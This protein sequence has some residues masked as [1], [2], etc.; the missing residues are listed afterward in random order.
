MR[1][2]L[3][4]SGLMFLAQ[5]AYASQNTIGPN[6]I[7]SAGLLGFN[8]QVLTGAGVAIGQVELRRPGRSGTDLMQPS[9]KST[10]QPAG[11]FFRN[12]NTN[13]TPNPDSIFNSNTFTGDIETHAEEVAGVM[14]SNASGSTPS[15]PTGVAQGGI[16]VFGR[17]PPSFDKRS[18]C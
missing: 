16:V 11:V 3:M 8:G 10:V 12:T 2:S 15:T 4:V 5:V 13:F 14:I 17:I 1:Y 7:D 6:G 9:Y 18:K